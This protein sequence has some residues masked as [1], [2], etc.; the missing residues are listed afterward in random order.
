MT[1]S[2]LPVGRFAPSPSGALHFGSLLAALASFLDIRQRGG[3]WLV[4]MED[5]DPD[6]EPPG[7]ADE[8]LRLLD[9]FR[10][11]WDGEVMYQSQRLEIYADALRDLEKQGRTYPCSCPRRRVRELRGRYDGYCARHPATVRK[12]AAI[13][14]RVPTGALTFDD[15]IQGQQAFDLSTTCGDFIVRRKDGLFAYQLATAVDDGDQQ[16]TE[17]LRG[18]DLLDSTPRQIHLQR[19]LGLAVPSHAHI[20][21]ASNVEGQKL[22]KQHFARPLDARYATQY[23]YDALSFL[24]Q[25]P[26]DRLKGA[27]AGE[28]LEW[29]IGHWDIQKVPRVATIVT[30]Q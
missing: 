13:R 27:A 20:P 22:S 21:V 1:D 11:H 14:V 29:G 19:A 17:V 3:R 12:P 15:R 6:R 28:L 5:L 4:R 26:P 2:P 25:Q 18:S 23:L 7:A 16:I 8:I 9:A 24:G 30:D 10:L